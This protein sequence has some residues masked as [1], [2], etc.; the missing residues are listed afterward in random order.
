MLTC[1]IVMAPTELLAKIAPVRHKPDGTYLLTLAM[2]PD[3]L[4]DLKLSKLPGL[5]DDIR[6][7]LAATGINDFAPFGPLHP[8]RP[9]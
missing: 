2:L 9:T 8:N 1:S 5:V 4:A 6:A 7:Q 3:A